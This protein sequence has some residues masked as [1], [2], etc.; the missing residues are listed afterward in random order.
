MYLSLD[1]KNRTNVN[2]QLPKMSGGNWQENCN[3][4]FLANRWQVNMLNS[5]SITRGSSTIFTSRMIISHKR[6]YQPE[7]VNCSSNE[8]S[9]ETKVPYSAGTRE[10]ALLLKPPPA[11]PRT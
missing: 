8:Q 4:A 11:H 5:A 7:S 1:V 9:G 2:M 3:N 6:N 10:V